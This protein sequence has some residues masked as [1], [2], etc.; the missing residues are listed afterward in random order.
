MSAPD[1]AVLLVTW[2]ALLAAVVW[3]SIG[4]HRRKIVKTTSEALAAL[5]DLNGSVAGQLTSEPMLK[6][7]FVDA[8][9]SKSKFDRYSLRDYFLRSVLEYEAY[10]DGYVSRRLQVLDIYTDYAK[11]ADYLGLTLLGM[12]TPERMAQTRYAKVEQRLFTKTK[13]A[14]PRRQ[15]R[16]ECVVTYRSPKGQN[17]YSQSMTWDFESLRL[18][19]AEV[20][21]I[22]AT[23]QTTQFLRKLE[24]SKMTD[25]LRADI[26]RRDG[27]RCRMCGTSAQH[28]AVLHVD[29]IVAVSRGGQTVSENLQAL[30][31]ACN[32]G[33][34]NR[35]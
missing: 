30:C 25:R 11:R 7:R 23:K 20:R 33:K 9:S 4:L 2:S 21:Q 5:R 26:L 13:L 31:Q 3:I 6:Q 15:A 29:H 24:R 17:S 35:F 16:V 1:V 8:V 18:A 28:G 22:Q 27:Y 32:L 19:I 34:S 10:F 12:T 14:E